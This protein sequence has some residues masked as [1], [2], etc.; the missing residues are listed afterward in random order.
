MEEVVAGIDI[1]GTTV[2]I[3]MV[4]RDGHV[5]SHTCLYTKDYRLPEN[6]ADAIAEKVKAFLYDSE[7]KYVLKGIGVGAP[8][9]NFYKGTIEYAPNIKWFGVIPFAEMLAE[10]VGVQCVLTNDANAAALGEMIFGAAK[11]IRDFIFI[12][13]GTGL[14]S[15]IVT[16][17]NLVYGHD[18]FA[19]ELGHVIVTPNGRLCG[20]GRT[21]CLEAYCSAPGLIKTYQEIL[22]RQHPAI[23]HQE[24]SKKKLA[25]ITAKQV[26][27]KALQ[28]E[29][30]ALEAFSDMAE[31]LGMALANAVAFSSPKAIFLFG[32][33]AASGNILFDNVKQHMEKN[34]LN[35]YKGKIDIL[36]SGL[37]ENDAALLGA[38]SLIWNS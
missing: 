37:P 5:F 31:M 19:G 8:N 3:G 14:G 26:H 2:H 7:G 18:G 6:L 20:C 36:P 30:T 22:I 33:L 10:R 21:G 9:G 13:L 32:G 11:G 27:E 23:F 12:T 25:E 4:T 29:S 16:N 24:E 15:G 38:A 34:L 1:G 35:I 17:G 28:G